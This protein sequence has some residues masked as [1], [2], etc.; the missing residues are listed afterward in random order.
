MEWEFR[1]YAK[2]THVLC[3]S[4]LSIR[5][6]MGIS[7]PTTTHCKLQ[8]TYLYVVEYVEMTADIRISGSI[9]YCSSFIAC[10]REQIIIIRSENLL[11]RLPPCIGLSSVTHC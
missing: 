2:A 6:L 8:Y 9:P 10:Q 5:K 1:A 11:E 4:T 3:I 7:T